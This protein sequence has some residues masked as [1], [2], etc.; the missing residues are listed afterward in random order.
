MIRTY[1]Q[2]LQLTKNQSNRVDSWIGACR[3]VFNLGM[4]IKNATYKATGK[5]ASKYDL[6]KQL[7]D[8]KEDY[9]WIKDVPS[10]SLQSAL[11]RL[12]T[13]YQN[14][15]KNFKKGGGFPRFASKRFYKSIHFKA[16][17]VKNNVIKLPKL[18]IVKT[19]KDQEILGIPKNAYVIKEVTGYFI[20]VQCEDVP[21]KFV[22]DSQTIGLDL[23]ISHFAVDS[24]GC[25][26]ANPRHFKKYEDRL[27]VANRS[28]SRK[29]KG[30]NSWKK[31]ATSLSKLHHTIGNVRKDF[32]H[33]ESTKIAK[34]NKVVIMEDLKVN[35]MSKNKQLSKHIL[36]CGW[37]S[38]IG[39]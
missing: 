5:S 4:E 23:G 30:S 27:R 17:S 12:E 34:A 26:I 24:D 2:K 38:L 22:S 35:N 19:F 25:F 15:F 18:G 39:S 28:L 11:D 31:Q 29:K 9:E 20:C 21:E 7:P 32:L 33:K 10:Q 36:D 37:S 13:S 6:M 16:V 3:V 14:F 1:K 8:L